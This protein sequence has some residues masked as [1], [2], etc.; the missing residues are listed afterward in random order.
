MD[1]CDNILRINLKN[2][3]IYFYSIKRAAKFFY[4][5]YFGLKKSVILRN[6]LFTE[7][8]EDVIDD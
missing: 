5:L 6:L 1:Y 7:E 4:F 2:R 8:V 3:K